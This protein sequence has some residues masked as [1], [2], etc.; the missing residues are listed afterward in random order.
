V[1]NLSGVIVGRALYEGRFTV[2]EAL[3]VLAAE[4]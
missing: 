3:D 4:P 2:A 1:P